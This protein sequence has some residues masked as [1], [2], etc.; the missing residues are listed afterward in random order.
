MENPK[1]ALTIFSSGKINFTGAKKLEDINKAFVLLY[2]LIYK[3]KNKN[4]IK[5]D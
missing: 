1:I 2:P 5:N 3:Y 4:N